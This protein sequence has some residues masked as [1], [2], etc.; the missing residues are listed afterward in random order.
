MQ[1]PKSPVAPVMPMLFPLNGSIRGKCCAKSCQ[2]A[3][4]IS[5]VVISI[6]LVDEWMGMLDAF[7][8]SEDLLVLVYGH[9]S[10]E[11]EE[12]GRCC[13]LDVLHRTNDGGEFVTIMAHY[14]TGVDEVVSSFLDGLS[15]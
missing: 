15:V 7:L 11:D 5:F 3:C 4:S 8:E 2:S 9:H 10:S 13:N 6:V 14:R 12:V 1:L